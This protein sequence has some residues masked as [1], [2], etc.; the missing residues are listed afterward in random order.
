V[1][2]LE[3]ALAGPTRDAFSGHRD[4]FYLADAYLR[5]HRLDDARRHAERALDLARRCGQLGREACALRLL[6]S[7]SLTLGD[8]ATAESLG[9]QA[10]Q[11][12]SD[13]GMRPL[14]AHCHASLAV[15]YAR[16]D[17]RA[18]A[19]AHVTAATVLYDEMQM[20]YWQREMERDLSP[21]TS[22]S[23]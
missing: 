13:L 21:S 1:T 8:D 4:I 23:A 3:R 19:E 14:V 7:I 16:S 12:G 17:K 2:F 6:S 22:T 5:V 9:R 20:P 15:L 10:L 11:L 18:N